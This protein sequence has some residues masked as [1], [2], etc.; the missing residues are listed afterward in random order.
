M[1]SGV[2]NGGDVPS[3]PK[4]RCES[5]SPI[6][7]FDE[8]DRRCRLEKGHDGPHS[9]LTSDGRHVAVAAHDYWIKWEDGDR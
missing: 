2:S 1:T 4:E 9:A 7:K 8:G 3:T 6:Y 5:K